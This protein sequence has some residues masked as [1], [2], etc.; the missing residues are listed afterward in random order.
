M[1]MG[2]RGQ[3][4][5]FATLHLGEAGSGLGHSIEIGTRDQ[6]F[7]LWG[8]RTGVCRGPHD[9]ILAADSGHALDVTF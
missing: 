5:G 7:L 8:E 4:G 9:G 3:S 2:M 6:L 1:G